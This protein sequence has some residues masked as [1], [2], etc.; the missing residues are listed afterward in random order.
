[1]DTPW[2]RQYFW[3]LVFAGIVLFTA[4]ISL[5]MV[6]LCRTQFSKGLS[7]RIQKSF[8]QKSRNQTQRQANQV[9]MDNSIY[10]SSPRITAANPDSRVDSNRQGLQQNTF[11]VYAVAEKK[12]KQ[13]QYVNVEFEF[14]PENN[15]QTSV[16]YKQEQT[17]KEFVNIVPEW[18]DMPNGE[19][20][21]ILPEDDDINEL[22]DDVQF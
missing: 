17:G 7:A 12:E 8:R 18:E 4:I 1:M 22:Y 20:I 16:E 2:Y 9:I 5:I 6:C 19:Y 3:L 11:P 21:D 15:F 13:L 10:T 14:K